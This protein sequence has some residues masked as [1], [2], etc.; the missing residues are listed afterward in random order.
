MRKT[1]TLEQRLAF[2]V[3]ARNI[4]CS[5]GNWDHSPYQLGY[6]NGIILALAILTDKEPEFLDPPAEWLE[7]KTTAE[8][9]TGNEV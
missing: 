1:P 3:N 5:S 6:A 2:L 8:K 4:Q 7:S 9:L